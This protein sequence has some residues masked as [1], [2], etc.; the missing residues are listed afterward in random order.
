[1]HTTVVFLPILLHVSLIIFFAAL[2]AFLHP[3]NTLLMTIAAVMLGLIFATYVYLTVL[4]ICSSDCLYRTPLSAMAWALF[5]RLCAAFNARH[6]FATDEESTI[7]HHNSPT[8]KNIPTLTEA[9]M[10]D[11]TQKSHERDQRDARAIVWT[12]DSLTNNNE[13]GPFVEALPDL[14]LGRRTYGDMIETLLEDPDIPL[15][16]RIETLLQSCDYGVLHPT[17]QTRRFSC[18]K[19][20]W[21]LANFV[22]SHGADHCD[23]LSS[24]VSLDPSD[25]PLLIQRSR[26]VLNSFDNYGYDVLIGYLHNSAALDDTPYEFEATCTT[27][28][29]VGVWPNMVVQM[30]LRDAFISIVNA[31]AD[32]LWGIEEARFCKL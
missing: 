21:S 10:R 13:L 12:V 18:I 25:E 19:A 20:L 7:A 2:V 31:H 26:E 1:M 9:M 11:A 17:L 15:V 6:K 28:Q 3:I 32:R 23:D 14:I 22:G 16:S 24:L 27:I 8:P 29:P 4:P 30:K 5:L